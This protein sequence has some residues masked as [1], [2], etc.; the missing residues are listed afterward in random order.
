MTPTRELPL[1]PLSLDTLTRDY[2]GQF[3]AYAI[4]QLAPLAYEDCF[5]PK[6]YKAPAQAQE[7]IAGYGYATYGLTVTP[8]SLIYGF[9]LPALFSTD[10]P[11]QWNVQ[12]TDRNLS[13]NG[14]SRKFWDAPIPSILIA[15]EKSTYL[16]QLAYPTAGFGGSFPN[17]LVCPYPVVGTGAF[18][19][20]LWNPT[21]NQQRVELIIGVLENVG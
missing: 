3:D 12:I 4:A 9:Y 11:A 1:S 10:Q 14:K 20:E 19:V 2:W 18:D 8:G 16:S 5:Q 17:L 7:L 6:L 13:V 15:N 21:Q